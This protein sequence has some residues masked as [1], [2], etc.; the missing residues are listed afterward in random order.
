MGRREIIRVK[1][2]GTNRANTTTLAVDPHLVAVLP[3][4]GMWM[5]E[6]FLRLSPGAGAFKWDLIEPSG[7]SYDVLVHKTTAGAEI[8]MKDDDD[9]PHAHAAASGTEGIYIVGTMFLVGGG[10]FA[11]HWAQNSSNAATTTL[12]KAS[13]MRLT[14]ID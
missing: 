1:T 10:T 14:R 3:P 5:I 8:Q 6:I 11:L 12:N 2:S 4:G 9:A 13:W 7:A